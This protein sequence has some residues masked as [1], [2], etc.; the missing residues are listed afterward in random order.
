MI[1]LITLEEAKKKVLKSNPFLE[2]VNVEERDNSYVIVSQP[3]DYD[4]TKN[5]PYIGGAVIVDKK[6]GFIH[7]YIP[8]LGD[9]DG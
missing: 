2:V 9:Q 3:Q 5:G 6:D 1:Y 4:I 8:M 7:P